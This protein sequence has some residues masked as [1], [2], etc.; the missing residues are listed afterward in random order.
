MAKEIDDP[1]AP[2]RRSAAKQ[3][4]ITPSAP[5]QHP[6]DHQQAGNTVTFLLNTTEQISGDRTAI[7]SASHELSRIINET[8]P[9]N[10]C[11]R[12]GDVNAI[13]LEA[14]VKFFETNFIKFNDLDDALQKLEFAKR[15]LCPSLVRRCVKEVDARLTAANVIKVY[16]TIRF[17]VVSTTPSKVVAIEKRTPEECLEALLYNVFQ[18]IDMN[19]SVVLQ[20]DEILDAKLNFTEIEMILRRDALMTTETD[21]FNLIANWSRVECQNRNLDLTTENRRRVLGPLSYVP[22]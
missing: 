5:P 22:R 8:T 20:R 15:Y 3:P 21:I 16:R 1:D 10:G 2:P 11:Y 7:C 12:L 9:V 6:T 14:I 18:F 17:H 19:A 13:E 4:L